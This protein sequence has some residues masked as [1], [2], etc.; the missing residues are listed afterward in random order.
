M[1]KDVAYLR[2]LLDA[3]AKIES[4]TAVGRETFIGTSHWH[5]AAMR[6]LE[7]IGAG[8][9]FGRDHRFWPGGRAGFGVWGSGA[10]ALNREPFICS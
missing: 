7:I 3:I 2:H 4:Y 8:T 1:S 5:D 9:G 10:A 6:Q